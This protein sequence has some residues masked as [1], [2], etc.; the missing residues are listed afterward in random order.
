MIIKDGNRRNDK[1]PDR[2]NTIEARNTYSDMR[3]IRSFI[4]G[5]W[6]D[7]VCFGKTVAKEARL[8]TGYQSDVDLSR[9]ADRRSELN[10]GFVLLTAGHNNTGNLVRFHEEYEI[11]ECGNLRIF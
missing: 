8:D 2:L 6:S 9:D 5:A 11:L 3:N 10:V 1:Y 7:E 4:T